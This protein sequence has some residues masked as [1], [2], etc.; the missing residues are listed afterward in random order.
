M[1]EP[2]KIRCG[3]RRRT[4]CGRQHPGMSQQGC[5]GSAG[6]EEQ[7]MQ[8]LGFPRNLG[9]SVI[10]AEWK[11]EWESLRSLPDALPGKH[12]SGEGSEEAGA[13]AVSE[14]EGNEA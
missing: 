13:E 4:S 1:I 9:G 10:S 14:A 8:A 6:V 11:P 3:S 12:P 5:Q 2:R 7:G